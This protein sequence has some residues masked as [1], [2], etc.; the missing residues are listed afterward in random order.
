M[1]PGIQSVGKV[2]L[3]RP[4]ASD[5]FETGEPVLFSVAVAASAG[6]EDHEE[7]SCGIALFD[8]ESGERLRSAECS[9]SADRHPS[10]RFRFAF[11]LPD[12]LPG[13]YRT[14]VAFA[15]RDSGHP[16]VTNEADFSVRAA[17]GYVPEQREPGPQALPFER[18]ADAPAYL[19]DMLPSEAAEAILVDADADTLPDADLPTPKPLAPGAA[20]RGPAS[21][22]EPVFAPPSPSTPAQEAPPAEVTTPVYG[23]E[24]ETEEAPDSPDP[25][26]GQ[27]W[28]ELPLPGP[29]GDAPAPRPELE[30]EGD[31]LHLSQ[32]EQWVELMKD[33]PYVAFM[34]AGILLVVLLIVALFVLH[35]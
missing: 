2:L 3:D 24:T 17:A 35:G 11:V 7:I 26:A 31:D 16:P 9:Y 28:T 1:R 27:S 8:E 14:K 13:R 15:I 19:E 30:D 12:L 20:G 21:L 10:G 23:E 22:A 29:L 25:L 5:T 6:V 4:P 33:D 18:A 32:L 34:G